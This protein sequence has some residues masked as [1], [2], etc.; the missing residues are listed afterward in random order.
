[1]F[2]SFFEK[3][4]KVHI[5]LRPRKKGGGANTFSNNIV[6]WIRKSKDYSYEKNILKADLAIVIAHKAKLSDVKKAAQNGCYII[7]RLDEYFEQHET[8]YRKEKHSKI[9]ALNKLANATVY[10]SEF[11]YKNV[12]PY[13]SC[14]NYEIIINGADKRFFSSAQSNGNYIGHV[15]WS[16]AD[17]KHFDLLYDLVKKYPE[18][19][20]LLVGNHLKTK[21]DFKS[22]PNVKIVKA[23]TRKQMMRYYRQ[24]KILYLPSE[25][26]PCPNTAVEALMCGIPVCYNPDGGTKEIVLDCGIRLENFDQ[27]LKNIKHYQ[28]LTKLRNDLD[29]ENVAQKYMN[30]Y[31]GVEGFGSRK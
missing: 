13:L 3:K 31:T 9:I 22:L 26:D 18:E 21:Y 14:D 24:M 27:L 10:Q 11:V 2:D 16:V 28:K 8:E 17:R 19:R 23:S 12:S 1:M 5:S 7:H 6:N 29:F 4:I 30:I 25:K 15:S 20:F